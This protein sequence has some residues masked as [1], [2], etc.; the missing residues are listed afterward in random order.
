MAIYLVHHFDRISYCHWD[1]GMV[2]SVNYYYYYYYYCYVVIVL[3][4]EVYGVVLI[5][6]ISYSW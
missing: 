2:Q 6:R 1:V 3:K 5:Q 4:C